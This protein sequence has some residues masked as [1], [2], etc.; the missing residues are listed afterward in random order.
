M[1]DLLTRAEIEQAIESGALADW[2]RRRYEAFDGTMTEGGKNASEDGNAPHPCFFAVEA[3][4]AGD[5]RYLFP[6]SA[7]TEA[8]LEAVADGLATY[9]D[10]APDIVER[11]ES[12]AGSE[13]SRS[14]MGSGAVT[15]L[16]IF[17]E[18]SG[19]ERSFEAYWN[20]F[21]GVLDYLHRHDPEPWPES[22]PGDP[23]DP[24][25]EFCYA[26]VSMF[27]VARAPCYDARR[28][29]YAPHG[30]EITVQPRWVFDGIGGDTE[31]G[32]EARRLIRD[33]LADYDD[34]G[35]HPDIGTYGDPEVHEWEQYMLPDSNDERV[36]EFPVEDWSA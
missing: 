1:I 9:L 20:R 13:A 10:R 30:L 11:S 28:S 5:M 35:P 31:A 15:S 4:E 7:T 19:D 2:K 12:R 17:F 32:Q 3:H 8:G 36:E 24:Q 33:R 34:F 26:G 22:V 27:V 6:G 25:W 18:P 23:A 21:W 14:A 16:A 29:R